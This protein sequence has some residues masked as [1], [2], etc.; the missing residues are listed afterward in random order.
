MIIYLVYFAAS[1][2]FAYLAY[3]SEDRRRFLFF[4][5]VSIAIPVFL[6][7][8]RGMNIG[9][10]V[11]N[12]FRLNR[13]WGHAVECESLWA[14]LTYYLKTGYGEILFALFI[15]LIG[16]LTGSFRVFL[17]LSHLVIVTGV[18]IG[19]FRQRKHVNPVLVL[20]LFYL[21]FFSHSLNIIRQYMA[22]AI[23]FA[24]L[25]DVEQGKH[26]RYGI[27]VLVASLIHSTALLAFG[28][29][30]VYWVLYGKLNIRLRGE[31]KA[32]GMGV[33]RGIIAGGL[34][35]VVWGFAPAARVL[36][37]VGLLPEKYDFYLTP[38]KLTPSLIVMALLVLELAAVYLR[39]RKIRERTSYIDFFVMCSVSYLILQQLTGMVEYGKRIAAYYSLNNIVTIALLE[40]ACKTRKE[41]IIITGAIVSIAL[42]Y[43]WYMYIL[44]NAS[45]T[46]PYAFF[47]SVI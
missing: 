1:A 13:Y 27:V 36:L 34:M 29:L 47:I 25:A 11:Q 14:Y 19:A 38:D 45:E 22:M 2:Y 40:S 3:Q 8:M 23:I 24:A 15:G 35:I 16:Q 12:Y 6:A 31:K 42:F 33:R 37:K 9:I 41:R 17:M 5:A 32:L 7:G 26:L 46:Y 4:S 21:F 10:D 28:A 39:R 44:R 30:L 20:V 43:W 18:Y